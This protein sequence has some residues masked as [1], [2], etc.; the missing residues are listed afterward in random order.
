MFCHLYIQRV[1]DAQGVPVGTIH[2]SVHVFSFSG[3]VVV[4]TICVAVGAGGKSLVDDLTTKYAEKPWKE[5]FQLVR[6]CMGRSNPDP[7]SS[8]LLSGCL[9]RLQKALNVS[10]LS[11]MVSRLEIIAK[12]RGLGSHLSPTETAC[13][14]T[15]DLFYLEVL[16]KPDGGVEDVKVALHGE[17]PLS[18]ALLLQ[19]LRQKKF[20]DF[21]AKLCDLSSLYNIPGDNDAKIKVCTALQ[22]M[23]KD[24]VTISHL[25][26]SLRENDVYIDTVLNGRVGKI[27][28]S[29]PGTPMKIQ[30]SISPSDMLLQR[31]GADIE[32]LT[33]DAFVMLGSRGSTHRLQLASLIP[34]PPQTDALGFP[35]FSPIT[36]VASESLQ[37]CFTLK[38]K[39]P[40]AICSS[41]IRRMEQTTD[42]K[43]EAD[44]QRVPLL[45]LLM[46]T[47]L[48][49]QGF[50]ESWDPGEEA[51]FTVALP[52]NQVHG[53]VLSGPAWSGGSWEGALIDT[54]PFTHP[55]HVP[56]LLELLRHQSALNILLASCITG[57][58]HCPGAS[59]DLYCEV[60]PVSDSSVSVTFF[61]PGTSSL[62]VLLVT[63]MH[64][65]QVRCQL[66]APLLVDAAMNDYISRVTTR[67]MSIPITMRAIYKSLTSPLFS[68]ASGTTTAPGVCTS[69]HEV[70]TA[71]S[72]M[73][74]HSLHPAP[75][76]HA[77]SSEME[78]TTGEFLGPT[79]QNSAQEEEEEEEE[80]DPAAM[81]TSPSCYVMSVS[82]PQEVRE[83]PA[84]PPT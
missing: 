16:L 22:F 15:A 8:K 33:R 11:T 57:P 79:P 14:L 51:N 73:V 3:V 72:S 36:E 67:C 56:S 69:P 71:A 52:G 6:R 49:E 63:V 77:G 39:P 21:S 2:R 50:Q 64:L 84:S 28:P 82:S 12:Q 76:L 5:T 61:L 40:L 35:L 13:Y 42:V 26:R 45:Q 10:S 44:Q 58:K 31:H 81:Y 43:P 78:S 59:Y 46:R 30:Y 18:S 19:L 27:V 32:G 37:A 48:G 25:P 1:K 55:A 34:S 83:V 38:L 62:A 20:E 54:I 75:D 47:T 80:E 23:E 9:Q 74:H 29:G 68:D 24:L 65:C 4:N 17:P 53:Y 41:V 7:K 70:N 66:F 60:L